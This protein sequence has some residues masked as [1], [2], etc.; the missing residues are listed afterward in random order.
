M[1]ITHFGAKKDN[2]KW[3]KTRKKCTDSMVLC[4]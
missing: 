4:K 3:Q 2:V 1:Q